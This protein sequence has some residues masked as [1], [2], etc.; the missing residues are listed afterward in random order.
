[1]VKMKILVAPQKKRI[2]EINEELSKVQEEEVLKRLRNQKL[3]KK[4]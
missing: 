1:M 2:D 3:L 4:L